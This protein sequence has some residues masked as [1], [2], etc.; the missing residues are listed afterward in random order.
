MNRSEKRAA[1]RFHGAQR[2]FGF[3]DLLA[4]SLLHFVGSAIR[5]SDDY[6]LRQPFESALWTSRD[7]DD[8][9]G[10]RACLARPGR[11]DDREIAVQFVSKSLPRCF[12][13]NRRHFASPSSSTNAGWV[14]A[15]FASS[16]SVSIG[17]VARG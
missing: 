15:H 10:D 4:R 5:V 7:L 13:G 3:E 16:R 14:S 11:G 12:V 6:E 2:Q 17:R 1:E 9:I 8:P